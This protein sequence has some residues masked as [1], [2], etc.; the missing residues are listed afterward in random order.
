MRACVLLAEDARSREELYAELTGL[1][2]GEAATPAAVD[3][4]RRAVVAVLRSRDRDRLAHE[5]DRELL[6]LDAQRTPRAIAV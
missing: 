6:G 1:A 2:A 4:A 5:L 3:A